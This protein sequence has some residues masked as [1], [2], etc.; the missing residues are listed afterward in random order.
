[1][2]A[3]RA[4]HP[5]LIIRVTTADNRLRYDLH[6]A[7][8]QFLHFEG[9]LLRAD[10]EKFRYDLIKELEALTGQPKRSEDTADDVGNADARNFVLVGE[11]VAER[12][13]QSDDYGHAPVNQDRP[14]TLS[15]PVSG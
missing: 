13:Q 1:M 9:E 5:D 8:T 3:P 12:P 4:P 2:D 15:R 6:F 14:A 10:P 7:D 11:T